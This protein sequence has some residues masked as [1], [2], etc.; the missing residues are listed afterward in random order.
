MR[1]TSCLTG[2]DS[3]AL[4]IFNQQQINF[5]GQFQTS[6]TEGQPYSDTSPYKVNECSLL[7]KR[8]NKSP[9]NFIKAIGKTVVNVI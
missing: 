2:W 5:F 7:E 6:Q 3:S 9:D 4:L 8:T 1:L